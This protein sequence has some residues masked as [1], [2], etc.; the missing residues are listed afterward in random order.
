MAADGN[1][2]LIKGGHVYDH[3]G[4]VHKPAVADILI[5]GSEIVEVG[6]DLSAERTQGA[7]ILDASNHLVIPGLINAHYHSHDTLCRGL[8]EEMPLEMWLLYSLPMG[9]QPLEGRGASAYAR[10]RH[11]VDA[12]RYHD[13]P[14]HAGAGSP[15]RGIHRRRD[16]GL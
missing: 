1:K 7:E 5:E 12:L 11:R 10:R 3:D 16:L 15:D 13:G 4:D 8:F 6:P 2:L 9:G 14:G